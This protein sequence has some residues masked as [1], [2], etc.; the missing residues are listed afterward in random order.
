MVMVLSADL[1]PSTMTWSSKFEN[2]RVL[3]GAQAK[4]DTIKEKISAKFPAEGALF[5]VN[6]QFHPTD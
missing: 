6:E 3:V 2:Y 4:I 5:T 1:T